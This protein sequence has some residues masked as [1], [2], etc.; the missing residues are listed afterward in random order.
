MLKQP[1]LRGLNQRKVE[2]M[3]DKV[4]RERL[5]LLGLH[6]SICH[7]WHDKQKMASC[8]SDKELIEVYREINESIHRV[9]VANLSIKHSNYYYNE[10]VLGKLGK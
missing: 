3:N 7:N 4:L 9:R 5:E 8:K 6:L 2:Q 1:P 10:K